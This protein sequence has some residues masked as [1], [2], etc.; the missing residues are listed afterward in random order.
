QHCIA[1]SADQLV[2]P[3]QRYLVVARLCL[4]VVVVAHC[5]AVRTQYEEL[6]LDAGLQP[7]AR[8]IGRGKLTLQNLPRGMLDRLTIE[9]EIRREPTDLRLPGDLDQAP[10]GRARKHGR[11]RRGAIE[12]VAKG[13]ASGAATGQPA[14]PPSP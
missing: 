4:P 11:R 1:D 14:P 9:I 13:A 8:R 6:G 5:P 2:V 12:D 7:I 3:Q 10:R